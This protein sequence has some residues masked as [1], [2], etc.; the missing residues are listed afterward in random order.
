LSNGWRLVRTKP[1]SEYVAAS[2]LERS[3]YM[4]FF[5]RVI[6]PRPRAGHNDAPLFPG[7]LFVR[8]EDEGAS[9]P[10]VGR[11]AGLIGWV[12]FDGV[13]PVV[14]DSVIV[15]MDARLKEVNA[16]GGQWRRYQPGDRVRVVNGHVDSLAEVLEEAKSPQSRVKVLMSF[17]GG[18]V[19]ARVPWYSLEPA[20]GQEWLE[21]QAGSGRPPRR[22]RGKGRWIKGFGPRGSQGALPA[23]S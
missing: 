20:G 22:T 13:I 7:Y 5:P 4:P 8:N 2:A 9:L 14:P 11:I 16:T 18:L 10:P 15:E 6:T 19:H 17:M 12:E 21:A 23:E 1:L 3:G